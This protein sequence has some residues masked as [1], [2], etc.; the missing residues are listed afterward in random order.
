MRL[1]RRP[2]KHFHPPKLTSTCDLHRAISP[3]ESTVLADGDVYR[4]KFCSDHFCPNH[5]LNDP[6]R[7][8]RGG[9]LGEDDLTRV[10]GIQRDGLSSKLGQECGAMPSYAC[11][12]SNKM[13]GHSARTDRIRHFL[14]ELAG[15]FQR[16]RMLAS[17]RRLISALHHTGLLFQVTMD[18]QVFSTSVTGLKVVFVLCFEKYCAVALE[19]GFWRFKASEIVGPFSNAC[20]RFKFEVAVGLSIFDCMGTIGLMCR[21]MMVTKTF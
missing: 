18:R 21:A 3:D 16:S 13:Y 10:S 4:Y 17:N 14:P 8:P 15:L 9:G 2:S 1:C 19:K 5:H 12:G 11:L 6:S 20:R 7:H